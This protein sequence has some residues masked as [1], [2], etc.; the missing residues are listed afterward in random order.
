MNGQEEQ[1]P[2]Q[3]DFVDIDK[4]SELDEDQYHDKFVKEMRKKE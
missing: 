4:K 1:E 3:V 2:E